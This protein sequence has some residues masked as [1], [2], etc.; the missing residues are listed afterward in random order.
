MIW[1]WAKPPRAAFMLAKLAQA[2]II[3]FYER[4][5]TRFV[6]CKCRLDDLYDEGEGPWHPDATLVRL[7][8]WRRSR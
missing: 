2:G 6:F 5:G 3:D 1:H 4:D 7:R 8:D